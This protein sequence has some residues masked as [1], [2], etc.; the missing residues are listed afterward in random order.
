[1]RAQ[2]IV[3]IR[4][5][6]V[7]DAGFKISTRGLGAIRDTLYDPDRLARR[8]QLFEALTLPSLLAQTDHDFTLA[9]LIG[10]DFPSDARARLSRLVAPLRD[11]RLIALPP[12]NNYKSTKLAM[13]A[14]LNPDATHV[15][16]VRLD[17]DDALGRDCIAAQKHVAP[18]VAALG[19]ANSPAVICFNNGLFLELSDQGNRL[20][21]VIEKLPLGIGMGMIAPVGARPTIFSTDHRRVHTRWNCYTEALTPRFIR[22][23]H[24]DNDSDA[25]VSGEKPKYSDHDLD[26]ILATHFPFTRAELMALKP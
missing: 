9:V 2:V 25:L 11:A 15:I 20:F 3:V 18:Q 22:T 26:R 4:F 16:S 1:M 19:P 21:G 24:R 14:C 13:D 17:D 10:D 12:H 6:Y 7:A 23:V 8:F 5:S